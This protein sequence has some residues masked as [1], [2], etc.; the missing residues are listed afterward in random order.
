MKEGDVALSALPQ[1]DG[2][3]KNRLWSFFAVCR[4]LATGLYAV[5]A[6]KFTNRL[7]VSTKQSK[8]PM[9]ITAGAD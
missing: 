1:A 3:I 9:L 4:D 2:Q 5:L 8:S 6:L 7:P